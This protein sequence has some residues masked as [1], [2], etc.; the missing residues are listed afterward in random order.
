MRC[1]EDRLRQ[2]RWLST[3]A[4]SGDVITE[5][6]VHA[7]N[8]VLWLVGRRPISAIGRTRRCRPH[9]HDDFREVYLIT[10]EFDDGLLWTHR[11]QSLR[12]QEDWAL[13]LNAYGDVATASWS[14][15]GANRISRAGPSISA[16]ATW[17]ACTTRVW[18]ETWPP[19][20]EISWKAVATILPFRRPSTTF[21]TAALGR[22]AAARRVCLTM[23]ELIKENKELEID[24]SSL[25]G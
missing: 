15:I 24:L 7:I 14:A 4:L 1:V 13:K 3:I 20:I 6:T 21:L 19:S 2:G 8:A 18:C 23:D 22:E 12:N 25:K 16:A 9:P 5:N 17:R 10:Y 11:C